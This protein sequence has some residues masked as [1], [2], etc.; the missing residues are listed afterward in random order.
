MKLYNKKAARI[1]RAPRIKKGF[2]LVELLVV[3]AIISALAGLS[4]GP[5]MK[6]LN[7]AERIEAIS[8]ARSI[9]TTLL[10]FYAQN[11]GNY[12]SEVTD[13]RNHGVTTANLLFQQILDSGHRDSEKFFWNSSNAKAG[14]GDINQPDENG[15]LTEGENVWDYVMNL[16]ADDGSKPIFYDSNTGGST[17]TAETWDGKAV[18]ALVDGA[19]SAEFI[20]YTGPLEPTPGN[21][22][23]GPVNNNAGVD[24]LSEANLPTAAVIVP[25]TD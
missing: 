21:F 6:Q 18:I 8:N 13:L 25:R 16:T 5:I 14:L 12:P 19:V 3:I 22:A 23:M 4:Y 7:A 1:R 17:F 15:T 11:D 10:V 20:N 9:N 2:T 24:I